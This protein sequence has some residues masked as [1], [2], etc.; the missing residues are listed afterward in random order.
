M[1]SIDIPASFLYKSD[2]GDYPNVKILLK[3]NGLAV[4]MGEQIFA[5]SRVR[6]QFPF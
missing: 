6:R 5:A 2:R 4:L 3:L 1:F